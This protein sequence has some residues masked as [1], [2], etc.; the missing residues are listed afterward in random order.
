MCVRAQSLHDLLIG[1]PTTSVA[2][3]HWLKDVV[4]LEQ[5]PN[6]IIIDAWS[7]HDA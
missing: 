7:F 1:H 4:V 2:L 5:S 3:A 6:V